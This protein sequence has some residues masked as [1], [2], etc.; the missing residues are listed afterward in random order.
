M[1]KYNALYENNDSQRDDQHAT[2]HSSITEQATV[3]SIQRMVR[4]REVKSENWI[5]NPGGWRVSELISNLLWLAVERVRPWF[6]SF[7]LKFIILH[8]ESVTL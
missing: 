6:P 7:P 3:H 1:G 8:T 4:P 5:G 2:P